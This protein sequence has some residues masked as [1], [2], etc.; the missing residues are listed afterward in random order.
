MFYLPAYEPTTV[1]KLPTEDKII[2]LADDEVML[3]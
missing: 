2:L 3:Q 1:E